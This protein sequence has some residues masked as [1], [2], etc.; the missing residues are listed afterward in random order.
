MAATPGYV[1]MSK[2]LEPI[3]VAG[4]SRAHTGNVWRIFVSYRRRE[5]TL[6]IAYW[7]KEQLEREKIVSTTGETFTLDIFVDAA[8]PHRPDFQANLVPRL[9]HSRALIVLA[10]EGAAS[11]RES[12]AEDYLYQE[13][14]WWAKE[15]RSAPPII[16]QLDKFGLNLTADPAFMRWRKVNFLPC[17]WE[18]WSSRAAAGE[19]EKDRLL[20][21]VK[22]S[23]RTY[24]EVVHI[25]EVRRLRLR[26]YIATAFALAALA[27]ALFSYRQS[28]ES[29][30]QRERAEAETAV[31]KSESNAAALA[32][33]NFAAI[34]GD[35]QTARNWLD[36]IDPKQRGWEWF[37]L[38][39]MTDTARITLTQTD[40]YLG[41]RI[42]WKTFDDRFFEED[43][44]TVV[45]FSPAR[46]VVAAGSEHGDLLLWDMSSQKRVY[47][48]RISG[49][50]S[51]SPLVLMAE[52]SP[53]GPLD[54]FRF[55]SSI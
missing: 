36:G 6:S 10:D 2:S 18:S 47:K 24:G 42:E 4:P 21:Q 49:G 26:A 1:E 45:D 25:Q 7:L 32:A 30:R 28:K 5:L 35:L 44:L 27:G 52:A 22:E 12:P 50:W 46:D 23:I 39:G 51:R 16:L 19:A 8:E 17:F 14:D 41:S 3:T 48:A 31:A 13:L 11:R 37:Y 20:S 34:S 33:A 38:R 43:K 9:Q 53:L 40:E 54:G 15:R 55:H 29:Q